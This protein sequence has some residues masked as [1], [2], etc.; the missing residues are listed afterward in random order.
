M[1]DLLITFWIVC[2][3][4]LPAVQSIG[5]LREHIKIN[6][7][8]QDTAALQQLQRQLFMAYEPQI[9]DDSL[10]FKLRGR[11]CSLHESSGNLILTP[12][13]QIF[14]TDV[15]DCRFY[16]EDNC[17]ILAYEKEGVLYSTAILHR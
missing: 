17:I 14:L 2:L 8:V 3:M 9:E 5:I 15:E 1:S 6:D 12:G 16:E 4:F 10:I 11:V 7:E 13:T